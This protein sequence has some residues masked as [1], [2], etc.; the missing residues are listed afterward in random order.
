MAFPWLR[1]LVLPKNG[2]VE[3]AWLTN[4]C[5]FFFRTKKALTG[6]FHEPKFDDLPCALW[7]WSAGL[8]VLGNDHHSPSSN[9]LNNW[10]YINGHNSGTFR[11]P[12]L[13][14]LHLK[15][16]PTYFG[17]RSHIALKKLDLM[18][19]RYLRSVPEMATVYGSPGIFWGPSPDFS[20]DTQRADPR[21]SQPLKLRRPAPGAGHAMRSCGINAIIHYDPI[22]NHG[23]IVVHNGIMMINGIIMW[24]IYIIYIYIYTYGIGL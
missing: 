14:L 20:P 18:Y 24:Y 6:E 3:I 17:W 15:K 19:G 23:N 11:Y 21:C 8:F 1:S 22:R 9:G 12:A 16:S 4:S 7:S 13:E 5:A 10:G 2:M